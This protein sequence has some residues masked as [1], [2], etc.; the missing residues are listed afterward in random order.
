MNK[1]FIKSKRIM[2]LL[3]CMFILSNVYP[4]KKNKPTGIEKK[5][6]TIW[7][8]RIKNAKGIERLLTCE[9]AL[10]SSEKARGLMFRE[11]LPWNECMIFVYNKP[12]ILHFWMKETKIPISIA[13]ISKHNTILEIF[14]MNAYSEKIV[15]STFRVKYAIEVNK[16]WFRKNFVHVGEK[17]IIDKEFNESQ[18]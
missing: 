14:E 6:N 2:F 13:Y 5:L 18:K 1:Q 4:N 17:I 7:K 12:D 16:L 11:K 10:T 3:G 8:I 15:S 9:V